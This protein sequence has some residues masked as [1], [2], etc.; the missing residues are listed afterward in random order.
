MIYLDHAA[1][2]FP[3]PPGVAAAVQRWFEE[4]GVSASRGDSQLCQVAG[5][6]VARVRKLLAAACGVPPERLIFTAG[7]TESLNTAFWGIAKP[8]MRVITTVLEHSSLARVLTHARE[9]LDLDLVILPCDGQGFVDPAR[10]EQELERAATHLLAFSHASNVLGSV[11]DAA[12]LCRLARTHGALSLVDAAASAGLWPLDLGADLLAS[13]AHKSL[14]GPPGLGILAVHPDC[15]LRPTRFGGTGSSQALDRQPE[16][17]PGRFESGT[18]NTPA[19]FGLGAA[20]DWLATQDQVTLRQA[21]LDLLDTLHAASGPRVTCYGPAPGHP[22][23]IPLLSF[24][25]AGL[26]PAEAGLLLDAQGIHVRT[27]FHCAP[28]IHEPLGTTAGGTIRVSLGPF[29]SADEI[30]QV[31]RSLPG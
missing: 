23:R 12:T 1:T 14:L 22:Q 8:A 28:W 31:P 18:P 2:S 19:I 30:A 17:W 20:L 15:P 4:V 16:T 7:A 25:V 29:V 24:N 5:A 21:E 13:S 6:E 26:D 3:K 11:Q 10:V 27:G 9:Q